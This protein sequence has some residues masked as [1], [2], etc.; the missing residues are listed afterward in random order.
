MPGVSIWGTLRFRSPSETFLLPWISVHVIAI[1]FP[2]SGTIFSEKLYG[3][4]PLGA[5]P[6]I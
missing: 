6:R 1:A 5:L 4:Y 3:G 2:K